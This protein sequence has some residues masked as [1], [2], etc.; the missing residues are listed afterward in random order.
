M[1]RLLLYFLTILWISALVLSFLH[2][3]P[4][5]P[6]SLLISTF[7]IFI[8]CYISNKILGKIFN[9]IINF[10]SVYIS[11]LILSLVITP[12]FSLL[13]LRFMV[14]ASII[15]M[16]SK[17][18]LA[19]KKKH[20]FNPVAIGILIPSL[21]SLGAASWWIGTPMTNV[22]ILILGV[23]I[24]RKIRR[25]HLVI[26]Y[27]LSFG[28]VIFSIALLNKIDMTQ[29]LLASFVT[30]PTL[31]FAFI[32]LTEPS[33]I[34]PKKNSQILYGSLI[35]V[36]SFFSALE[37]ALILGNILSYFLSPKKKLMLKLSAKN[38]IGAE[39]YEYIFENTEKF[40]YEAGQYLEWTINTSGMDSRGN[41]R[42]LTIASSPTEKD[43]KI[44]VKISEKS[45]KFKR[46]LND[47]KIGDRI[48][49][50][51]LSGD[52]LLSKK[53]E[54]IVF[55]AGGIGITPFRS[56][57][58]YMMDNYVKKQVI[59]FYSNKVA[60][61][62]VYKDVF[63]EAEKKINFK[64]FYNLTDVENA[65]SNWNGFKGR[66]NDEMLKKEVHDYKNSIFYLSGPH[67]MVIAFETTLYNMG[68]SSSK[69]KKDF[70]P[71][72]A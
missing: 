65:P 50:G 69:I 5:S 67:A 42:Y 49:A 56:M 66:I 62:I 59:L 58:K 4:F 48:L 68:V 11:A 34:P 13:D 40:N 45:S 30:S 46:A 12:S 64:T 47:L 21:F 23:L 71:G 15:A 57:V 43:F 17:Y 51:N 27:L 70:F 18:I 6:F 8:V 7:L 26:S 37:L 55:I 1:Y 63:D 29:I 72:Y 22:I 39:T 52:F 54:R 61:E 53:E 19:Y 10:E 2:I 28:M 24:T 60:D 33:T 14:I 25:P 44:G 3:F 35:G 16:A 32:M 36:L 9:A 41:R 20:I 31:F 38:K